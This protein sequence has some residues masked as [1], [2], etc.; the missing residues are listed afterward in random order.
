MSERPPRGFSEDTNATPLIRLTDASAIGPR[1]PCLVMIA[2]PRLGEI[3]PIEQELTI[4]RDPDCALRLADDESVSRRHATVK[5]VP[6]GSDTGALITD[7]KS[8]NGTYVDGSRVN[9]I[10]LKEGSKIRVGQTV[11]L[12]FACY[13][14]IEELAQRQLLEAALRDGLTHAF[15][16]RYFLQ[17][18]TA[19]IRFAERHASPVALLEA[20]A[21][22][23]AIALENARHVKRIHELTITDD[24]TSLYNARHLNFML[25]TEIYRS[26][27]YAFEFSLIF[28]DLDHFKQLNDKHGHL[29]G[30]DVLK[31]LVDLLT[32]TLRAED[33]L[34]RYGGEEFAVLARGITREQALMLAD[35]LRKLVEAAQFGAADR[36]PVT[37]SVGVGLF[38]FPEKAEDPAQKL[39]EISDAALYRAKQAG[40]NQVQS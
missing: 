13:D 16:R 33:V 3:F 9:E 22:F 36:V 7:L 10:V 12:K 19:E 29:T 20:L 4:G 26:H 38:P 11:V 18:L 34:A 15:N 31:K 40:R 24:C 39:I 6:A 8:A 14:A 2:G 21:D 28:I 25:D 37:I 35:R 5:A 1:R 30:D 23:A 32:E 17:R 27:R